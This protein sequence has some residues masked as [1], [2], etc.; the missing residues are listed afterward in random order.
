MDEKDQIIFNLTKEN[1]M[2]RQENNI[3]RGQVEK[4]TMSRGHNDSR[5]YSSSPLNIRDNILPPITS[6]NNKTATK[7]DFRPQ[8][9][10]I[11]GELNLFNDSPLHS[12]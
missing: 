6:T 4:Q 10:S 11:L 12:V 7:I 2:L 3:L 8:D 9:N 1:E 5:E